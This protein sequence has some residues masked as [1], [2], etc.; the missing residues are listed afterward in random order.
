MLVRYDS[1]LIRKDVRRTGTPETRVSPV[2]PFKG[3]S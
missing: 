3:W 1:I 2:L